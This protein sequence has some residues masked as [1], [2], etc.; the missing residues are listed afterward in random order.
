MSTA[1]H[2]ESDGQTERTNRTQEGILRCYVSYNQK[3]WDKWLTAAEFAYNNSVQASTKV[4]PFYLIY[5]SH[6]RTPG[7]WTPSNNPVANEFMEHMSNQLK[8]ALDNLEEA[9]SQQAAYANRRRREVSFVVGDKVLLSAENIEHDISANRPTKKLASR[10]LGPFEIVSVISQV[11]YKLKL[12]HSIKIH[13]VFHVSKLIPYH[14]NP[15]EF[16]LRKFSRPPPIQIENEDEYE[17]EEILDTRTRR[18]KQQYLVKWLG[19][20]HSDNTWEPESFVTNAPEKLAE[21]KSR[22]P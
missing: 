6:P 4:S 10:F 22:K 11:A 17:V 20:P 16:S 9:Q 12:P 5:G 14:E 1:Y 15:D 19:Y 13:P 21:F 3:D 8:I 7:I 2:P 18:G